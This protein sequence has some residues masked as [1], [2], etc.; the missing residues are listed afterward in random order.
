MM[1]DVFVVGGGINGCGIAR[2][3]AG[4]GL[5]V[6]LAEKDDLGAKTSSGS[7]KLLHGGLRYLEHYAFNLV[8]NS[9]IEREVLWSIAPHIIYPLRF[10]LPHHRGLRPSALLR[11]G[12]FIYDHLGGR[13]KLSKS[14]KISF[15][16]D[17]VGQP[18]RSEFKIGFE[19]SDCWVDDARLVL[20]N[21]RD[22]ADRGAKV[23]VHHEV[24]SARRESGLWVIN[25]RDR[26]SATHEFRA[27][28]LVNAAGP[29]VSQLTDSAIEGA[30]H[31]DMRLIRGSH[32]VVPKLYAH[33][34]CYLLQ[35]SDGRIVFVIPYEGDFSLIGTTDEEHQ[36]SLEKIAI[37]KNEAEYLCVSVNQYFK[38]SISLEDIVWSYSAVRPLFDDGTSDAKSITRDYRV[39]SEFNETGAPLISVLGGKITT[40]R[41][42]AE[43]VMAE[44]SHCLGAL[45]PSW[46]GSAPLPGGSFACLEFKNEVTRLQ[47]EYPFLSDSYAHRLMR[48]YGSLAHQI[49]RGA[50]SYKD[51]GRFFGGHL[52][53]NEVRYLMKY[54]WAMSVE[55]VLWRRTKEGLRLSD[56]EVGQLS[57]FLK[58]VAH[59]NKSVGP[60]SEVSSTTTVERSVA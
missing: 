59:E 56:N 8:R 47:E 17:E 53:E 60:N 10:V 42:L 37:E 46:T 26:H 4:R 3:A 58:E 22:A 25:T 52:Y 24:V 19:Y 11:L 14:R 30:V 44:I 32:I 49:L 45:G 9:L 36:E 31:R 12:L 51:L 27:R 18:L 41:K 40:Y 48:L 34:R 15:A 50:K 16:S 2:D 20:M 35:N 5:S 1:F 39:V 13:K 28:I 21:A 23:M 7:T 57:K 38:T 6:C 29:W 55:D 43:E 54:E 33:D